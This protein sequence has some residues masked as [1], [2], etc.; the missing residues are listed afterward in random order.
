MLQDGVAPCVGDRSH[1]VR[2]LLGDG[3]ERHSEHHATK[4]VGQG[5]ADSRL[6][7]GKGLTGS[8]RTGQREHARW[9]GNGGRYDS[10]TD[11]LALR[12]DRIG[13]VI[14]EQIPTA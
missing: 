12:G 7:R 1:N 11:L 3:D 8:G 5:V 9:R 2:H 14:Y 4:S 13:R 6:E 10:R